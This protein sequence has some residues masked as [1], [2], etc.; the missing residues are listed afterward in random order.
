MAMSPGF[1]H[2]EDDHTL[3]LPDRRGNNRIDSMRN[4][5]INPAIALLVLVPALMKHYELMVMRKF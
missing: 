2:I 4:L 3:L 5:L 1:I